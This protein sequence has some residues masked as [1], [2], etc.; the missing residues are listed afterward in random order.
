MP[1][2]DGPV[3]LEVAGTKRDSGPQRPSALQAGMM[4]LVMAV[5]STSVMWVDEDAEGQEPISG[6]YI[7][8]GG[9]GLNWGNFWG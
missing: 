4:A 6:E 7:A 5:G 8:I 3:D 1:S 2:A 9:W